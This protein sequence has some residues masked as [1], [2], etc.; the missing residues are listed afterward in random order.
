[1]KRRREPIKAEVGLKAFVGPNRQPKRKFTCRPH[2]RCSRLSQA[3]RSAGKKNQPRDSEKYPRLISSARRAPL[4]HS[5]QA[6][7]QR[8]RLLLR[9]D[10]CH[11]HHPVLPLVPPPAVQARR[12]PAPGCGPPVLGVVVG[13]ARGGAVA[14][15][16]AA[17]AAGGA[18]VA[19]GGVAVARRARVPPRRDCRAP[20]PPRHGRGGPLPPVRRRRSGVTSTLAR[21]CGGAAAAAS[22]GGGAQ[23][24]A[25]GGGGGRGE[26]GGGGGRAEGGQ[27]EERRRR[28]RREEDAEGGCRG[29]G[30][31]RDAGQRCRA[32]LVLARIRVASTVSELTRHSF[33]LF[34]CDG[35]VVV[36]IYKL[37]TA[38][39]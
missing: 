38:I 22:A 16:G 1:M 35:L 2:A 26:E 30:R 5:S 37:L 27:G 33:N 32:P 23:A 36:T 31:A 13:G 15:R 18:A 4:P 9:H 14:A 25:G 10:R 6:A 3:K 28:R 24:T 39:E 12:P 20:P 8:R 11:R 34:G 17:L 19:P 7:A 29:G 21:C